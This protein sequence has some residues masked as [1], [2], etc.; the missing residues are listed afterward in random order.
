MYAAVAF[1]AALF[2]LTAAGLA[3][4][5]LRARAGGTARGLGL[6]AGGCSPGLRSAPAVSWP[7]STCPS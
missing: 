4:R 6:G 1:A 7:W 2:L 3:E 5:H